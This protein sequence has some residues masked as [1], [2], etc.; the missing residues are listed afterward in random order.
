[1]PVGVAHKQVIERLLLAARGMR[2]KVAQVDVAIAVL[3]QM[4]ARQLFL[5]IMA[6]LQ[7]LRQK[8]IAVL[9]VY[10]HVADVHLVA[11]VR[12]LFERLEQ[13]PARDVT[14]IQ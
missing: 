5:H 13:V 3:A 14:K 1:M 9:V 12:P 4:H 2:R 7:I 10:L 6:A 11:A 8:I